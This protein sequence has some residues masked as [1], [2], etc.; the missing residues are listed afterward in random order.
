MIRI[1]AVVILFVLT[2]ILAWGQEDK[3]QGFDNLIN[4]T[5]IAE[6][7]WPNGLVFK[8]EVTFSY[9][10]N[11][12]IVIA[13]SKGFTDKDQTEY[14]NRNHGIRQYNE[15]NDRVEFWE[16]DVF[17]G[18][19]TGIVVFNGKDMYYQY[20]YGDNVFTDYWEYINDDTYKYTVG[21]YKDG[22]WEV[23][24]LETEFK[25]LENE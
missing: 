1:A 6:G 20:T 16:F 21:N 8:Q 10:L 25:K 13:N 15:A 22:Q 4:K 3:L 11:K 19:T 2:P 9:D 14:G 18:V 12:T 17:G 7:E 24:Y 5:W 23:I